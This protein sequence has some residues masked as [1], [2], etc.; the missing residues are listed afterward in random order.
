MKIMEFLAI[1]YGV[2]RFYYPYIVAY[3]FEAMTEIIKEEEDEINDLFDKKTRYYC[4]DVPICVSVAS[5]IGKYEKI[6]FYATNRKEIGRMIQKFVEYLHKLSD[7][8]Y[9]ILKEQ[10]ELKFS[11]LN[12]T[13]YEK[14][15][16]TEY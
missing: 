5:N 14:Y 7:K 4:R 16:I 2:K 9:K 3:D 6:N 11:H 10:M 13:K 12:L 8:A 15:K 1:K